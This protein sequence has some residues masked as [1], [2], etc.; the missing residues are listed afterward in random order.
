MSSTI[1]VIVADDH[2][3][4]REG[5]VKALQTDAEITVIGEV[6]DAESAIR[7]AR[8]QQPDVL[9]L[10][11]RMPGDGLQAAARI[12]ATCP[13]TRIVM[14]SMSGVEDNVLRALEVGVSGY[15]LKD[16]GADDLI[17]VVRAVHA[18][19]RYVAPSLAYGLLREKS[20]PAPP[21]PLKNLSTRERQVT[22]LLA[23]GL[24]NQQIGLRLGLSESTIK[25]YVGE[26]LTKLQVANRVEAA[27]LAARAT[28]DPALP[29]A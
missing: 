15:V 17:A 16:V 28:A 18:G 19:Q 4:Y 14:L 7:L 23:N 2:S 8:E 20:A 25:Y 1:R 11:V 6:A 3:L 13:D 26:I 24:S 22:A 5:V 9:L 29:R 10:D 12:A 27:V 21:D